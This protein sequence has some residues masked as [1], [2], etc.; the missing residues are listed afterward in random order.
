VLAVSHF[1]LAIVT[2]ARL[3]QGAANTKIELMSGNI[4]RAGGIACAIRDRDN[5]FVLWIDALESTIVLAQFRDGKPHQLDCVERKFDPGVWNTLRIEIHGTQF[6]GCLN[7]DQVILFEAEKPLDG[8]VSLW[9][10]R[11]ND[12]V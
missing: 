8:F 5:Y 12:L 7:S 2:H 3:A 1:P 4:H 10:A 11:F 9:T 6:K